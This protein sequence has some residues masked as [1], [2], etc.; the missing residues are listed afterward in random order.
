MLTQSELAIAIAAV[1]MGAVGLG[2]VLHWLWTR[3]GAR[4]PGD[5][6]RI[7]EMS[8]RMHQVEMG[9]EAAERALGEAEDRHAQREAELDREIAELRSDLDTLHGGLIHAR[10]RIIELE[11]ELERRRGG[12]A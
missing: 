3:L 1:L 2:A 5:G 4:R 8:E 10:Q 7:A 6:A 9:R 11:A 12:A